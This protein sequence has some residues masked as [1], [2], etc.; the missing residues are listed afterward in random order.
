MSP[1]LSVGNHTI[2]AS[3]GGDAN[4]KTS[5][6]TLAQTVN[7]DST[8]TT[9]TS[10]PIPSVYGKAVTFTAT[11]VANAPRERH[12]DRFGHVHGWHDDAAHSHAQPGQRRTAPP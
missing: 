1:Q 10:S 5:S 4:F 7:Q 9:V 8:T 3:Y 2:K 11:V 6:G 12:S